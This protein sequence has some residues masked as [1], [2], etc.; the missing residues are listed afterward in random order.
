MDEQTKVTARADWSAHEG[1]DAE[2]AAKYHVTTMTM[3]Q[4]F[5][6]RP[7]AQAIAQWKGTAIRCLTGLAYDYPDGLCIFRARELLEDY[8]EWNENFALFPEIDN[9]ACE[10][11]EKLDLNKRR[12][13]T[14][15]LCGE[16]VCNVIYYRRTWNFVRSQ[17]QPPNRD[18][19]FWTCTNGNYLDA[20]ILRWC[21][22]F[23]DRDGDH[24]WKQFIDI[25]EHDNFQT[26]LN[27]AL[28]FDAGEYEKFAMFVYKIRNKGVAHLDKDFKNEWPHL[29]Q[30][31]ASAIL[32]FDTLTAP[33]PERS[34][35]ITE[36]ASHWEQEISSVLNNKTDHL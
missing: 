5:N 22:L 8:D 30:I 19:N 6:P 35:N 36:L 34:R 1:T 25:Q 9:L 33:Y 28:N 13:R 27:K 23:M 14:A 17:T 10:L 20:A 12:H 18:E 2:V 26:S 24:H 29:D 11:R 32:L 16:I 21:I 15:E 4:Y 3:Q 31:R 7:V